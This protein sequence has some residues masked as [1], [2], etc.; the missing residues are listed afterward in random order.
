[1]EISTETCIILL[2]SVTLINS[3]KRRK[4]K[5]HSPPL[6]L[7]NLANCG[8]FLKGREYNEQSTSVSNV[9][10]R[11]FSVNTLSSLKLATNSSSLLPSG[12]RFYCLYPVPSIDLGWAC[13]R[14]GQ[15]NTKK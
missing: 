4:A 5:Y 10:N 14:F 2:T 8:T 1:M 11:Y 9:S 13:D 15:E 3:I 7:C 6:G 12:G